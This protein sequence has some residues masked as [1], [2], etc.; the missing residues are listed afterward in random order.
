[1]KVTPRP[2]L[3]AIAV[4][5]LPVLGMA[6]VAQA[7]SGGTGTA[8]T[9]TTTV[10]VPAT[11]AWTDTGIALRAGEPMSII[12][13]GTI[14]WRLHPALTTGPEGE[15]F[16]QMN[17]GYGQYV[18]NPPGSKYQFQAYGLHCWAALFRIGPSGVPFPTGTSTSFTS[19]VSGELYLGVNDSYFPDNSGAFTATI[20]S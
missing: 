5:I 8:S 6:G 13:S 16:S 15:A 17:C 10:V 7:S 3:A 2:T 9:A 14:S 11:Q 18:Q 4:L 12:M 19:P 20:T 1:V